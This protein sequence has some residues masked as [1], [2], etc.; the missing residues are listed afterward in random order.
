MSKPPKYEAVTGLNYQVKGKDRRVEP[1]DPA[2]D[3]PEKSIDWLLEQGHIK[4]VE[5]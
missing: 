4:L 1:G 3:L 5:E 2:T